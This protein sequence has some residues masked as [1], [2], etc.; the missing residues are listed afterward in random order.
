MRLKMK[1]WGKKKDHKWNEIH[2]YF[3]SEKI[4]NKILNF[5]KPVIK[6]LSS[7]KVIKI[8]SGRQ[9]LRIA[10]NLIVLLYLETKN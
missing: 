7:E 8:V 6:I 5:F 1:L 4:I 10:F 2:N 9:Y 3:F